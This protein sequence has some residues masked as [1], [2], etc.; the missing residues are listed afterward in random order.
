[1]TY[2]ETRPIRAAALFYKQLRL[3]HGTLLR[4]ALA[5]ALLAILALGLMLS[6]RSRGGEKSS[7]LVVQP[8]TTP[9]TEA[10]TA[11]SPPE[12]EKR[13]PDSA[14]QPSRQHGGRMNSAAPPLVARTDDPQRTEETPR[15]SPE[16][17]PATADATR[18]TGKRAQGA[19]L[20]EVKKVYVDPFGDEPPGW[21]IREL[22]IAGLQTSQRLT[23]TANREQADAVLK[24]TLTPARAG[25][26]SLRVRLVNFNGGV[27]WPAKRA[28]D[29]ARYQGAAG[30]V[31]DQI[32][33]DLL[34]EIQ[35]AK[36]R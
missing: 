24:V 3:G 20:R 25:R 7:E 10:T 5:F 31:A 14:P 8:R 6:W 27:L 12:T 9:T 35:R 30:A 23:I 15:V 17:D 13:A 19:A 29:G 21:Q 32:V 36:G 34:A 28:R 26:V 22:L 2:R 18:G 16:G 11:P 1:V 4:P 33:K